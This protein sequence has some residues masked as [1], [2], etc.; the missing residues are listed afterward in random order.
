MMHEEETLTPEPERTSKTYRKDLYRARL[1]IAQL[2]NEEAMASREPFQVAG[3]ALD[4][5]LTTRLRS[6]RPSGR[7]RGGSP[8][9]SPSPRAGRAGLVQPDEGT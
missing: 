7:E 1:V 5:A 2:R 8:T 6:P 9:T 3:L 4:A